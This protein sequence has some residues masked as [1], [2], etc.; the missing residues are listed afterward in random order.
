MPPPLQR[1]AATGDHMLQSY[2]APVSHESAKAA[3]GGNRSCSKYDFTGASS[4]VVG[5]CSGESLR[6]STAAHYDL[7]KQ[8]TI[9]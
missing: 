4:P 3:K 1:Y 9:E 8:M 6:N 7:H 5:K 2:P